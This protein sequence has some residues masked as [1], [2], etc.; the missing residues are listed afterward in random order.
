MNTLIGVAT[1]LLGLYGICKL[2]VSTGIPTRKAD[3]KVVNA[4]NSSLSLKD[5]AYSFSGYVKTIHWHNTRDG[6]LQC[7]L[8]LVSADQERNM[9]KYI[10]KKMKGIF[11]QYKALNVNY[12]IYVTY[13]LRRG[14]MNIKD[15]RVLKKG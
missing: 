14:Y 11:Q 10:N 13:V 7:W 8:T 12:L 2:C 9:S 5:N 1:V 3:S 15:M 4:K 6:Q